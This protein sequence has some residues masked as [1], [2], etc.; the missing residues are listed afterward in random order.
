MLSNYYHY[1]CHSNTQKY[2]TSCESTRKLRKK[3]EKIQVSQFH[4]VNGT[5]LLN[6]LRRYTFGY[7]LP[8]ATL[9]EVKSKSLKILA[10]ILHLMAILQD[11]GP[12]FKSCK[13]F[14]LYTNLTRYLTRFLKEKHFLQD[15]F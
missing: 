11:C 14:Q 4:C 2:R 12:K 15:L 9:D 8:I 1:H 10:N 13:I 6:F 3:R 7:Y 5:L